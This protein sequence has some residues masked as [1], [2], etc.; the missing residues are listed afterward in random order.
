MKCGPNRNTR[1]LERHMRLNFRKYRLQL[2][3]DSATATSRK[4]EIEPF[5]RMVANCL[6]RESDDV[7]RTRTVEIDVRELFC[8]QP[9]AKC[10]SAMIVAKFLWA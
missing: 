5:A 4:D 6:L 8:N 7:V 10:D 2:E 3:I 1:L 9:D